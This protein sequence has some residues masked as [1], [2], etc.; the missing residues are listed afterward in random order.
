MH[1]DLLPAESSA[2]VRSSAPVRSSVTVPDDCASGVRPG[3]ADLEA[4]RRD[5]WVVLRGAAR[6]DCVAA[7]RAEVLAV[8]ATRNM[9]DSYLAQAG[10]YLAGGHLDRWIN[11][12]RF[13]ALAEALL[14]GPSRRYMTFTAVKGA[15]QGA[16]GFHQDNSY[17]RHR[18]PSLNC[19]LALDPMSEANGCLRL[20]SRSHAAGTVA[21]EASAI[22]AGHRVVSAMPTAWHDVAME[23]GDLCVFDRDTVHGSGANRTA[24][25]RV[26]YAVQFH[27]EDTEAFFDGSWALLRDRPRFRTAPV[28][29]LTA[30]A[31]R[32][33]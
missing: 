3:A 4:F 15:G 21:A 20:V 5:G 6:A 19:W 28:A 26:A 18:G 30:E 11:S 12:P 14:G 16:F 1:A 7:L 22:N 25:P 2:A 8:L 27:R 23:P 33:E 29:A 24:Q 9:P 17:T 32:G 10:E 13:L 31:Q